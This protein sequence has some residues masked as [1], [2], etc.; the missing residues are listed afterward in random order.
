MSNKNLFS[1]FAF[2]SP[3]YIVSVMPVK[4]SLFRQ[5]PQAAR[6]PIA[7]ATIFYFNLVGCSFNALRVGTQGCHAIC[8]SPALRSGSFFVLK[9]ASFNGLLIRSIA[10]R[11]TLENCFRSWHPA[12]AHK[13][14]H[15]RMHN[16]FHKPLLHSPG[17][18]SVTGLG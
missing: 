13:A 5:V 17:S 1:K 9:P 4:R 15:S 14:K 12:A 8:I 3:V 10:P 6:Q 7:A 2:S 18:I 11:S 16:P